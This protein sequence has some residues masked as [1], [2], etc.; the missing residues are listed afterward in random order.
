M[1]TYE[2][3]NYLTVMNYYSKWKK[4][5]N[6]TVTNIISVLKY[7]CAIHGVPQESYSK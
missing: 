7:I 2:N 6:K 4:I 1:L 3:S 5:K